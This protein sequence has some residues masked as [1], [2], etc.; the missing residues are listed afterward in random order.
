MKKKIYLACYFETS[1]RTQYVDA[2]FELLLEVRAHVQA[3]VD[4]RFMGEGW[5]IEEANFPETV[6]DLWKLMCWMGLNGYVI[7]EDVYPLN[8]GILVREIEK[9][10][11]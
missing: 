2:M 7:E 6:N 8:I 3:K 10:N 9:I 1:D 4:R 11:P 5:T